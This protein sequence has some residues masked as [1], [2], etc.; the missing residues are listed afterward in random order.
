MYERNYHKEVLKQKGVEKEKPNK[1]FSWKKALITFLILGFL[2]G[3]FFLLRAPRLQVVSFNVSGTEV[4]DNEDIK[5]NLQKQLEGKWL[6]FFPRTSTFLL[7]TDK[8]ESN[9]KKEFSRIEEV[10]IKRDRLNAIS[11]E[12]KEYGAT[13]LWCTQSEVCYFMDKNGVVYNSAPVFSGSAYTKIVSSFPIEPL[14]FQALSV[15]QISQ[16]NELEKGLLGINIS[17]TAFNLINDKKIEIDFLHNKS[18]SKIILD[19]QIKTQSSLEYLFSALRTQD[20]SNLFTNE[21]KKLLYIDLRFSN[22]VV[23]KFSQD[24]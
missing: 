21:N 19:P 22:K 10:V 9:L 20:F 1:R 4:L 5:I 24:E 18:I 8:L 15:S 11:V 13:Y 16:I 14:P 2:V 17:P 12:I 3:I 23:Y 7:D 6:W